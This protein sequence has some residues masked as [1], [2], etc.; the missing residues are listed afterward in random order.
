[1]IGEAAPCGLLARHL[2][3]DIRLDAARPVHQPENG[4]ADGHE[5]AVEGAE[6]ENADEVS[7]YQL[8]RLRELIAS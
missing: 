1:M 6:D 2:P 8:Q 5:E 3:H 7:R 4:E